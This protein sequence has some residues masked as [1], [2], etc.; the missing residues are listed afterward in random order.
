[1]AALI[2]NHQL[3]ESFMEISRESRPIA[4]QT[5]TR[6]TLDLPYQG[7]VIHVTCGFD[8]QL[9]VPKEVQVA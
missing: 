9:I 6:M 5:K 1:V 7:E 8:E 2:F 3:K 4:E